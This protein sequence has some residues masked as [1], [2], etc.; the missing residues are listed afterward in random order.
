MA[1]YREANYPR[2]LLVGFTKDQRAALDRVSARDKKSLAGVVRDAV[3]RHRSSAIF[4]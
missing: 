3:D 2:K 1:Y 4:S